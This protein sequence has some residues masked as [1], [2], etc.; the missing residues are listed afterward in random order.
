MKRQKK[1]HDAHRLMAIIRLLCTK[2]SPTTS[3][4][5]IPVGDGTSI[6][7]MYIAT[8]AEEM[9]RMDDELLQAAYC[10]AIEAIQQYMHGGES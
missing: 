7:T 8:Y 10:A 3:G 2:R 9:Q 4:M 6:Q 5:I 1:I